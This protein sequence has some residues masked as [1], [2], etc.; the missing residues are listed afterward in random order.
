MDIISLKASLASALNDSEVDYNRIL[1]LANQISKYD[2]QNVRFSIDASHISRLGHELVSKQETAVAE[3]IKNA[4]DADANYVKAIFK[5]TYRAGGELIIVDDGLGMS[6]DELINGFMRISTRDK[7]ENPRSSKYKRQ[8][9]GR[10]GIGRFSAQRL[11]M[12]LQLTTRREEDVAGICIDIDWNK[13]EEVGDLILVSNQITSVP[14]ADVGTSLRISNLKD[15]WSNAQIQRAY[16][17]ISE[18]LQPTPLRFAPNKKDGDPGFR[19]EFYEEF[20]G[21]QEL[22]ASE[23]QN[24]LD[25]AHALI[26]GYVDENG[27]PYFSIDSKRFNY[28]GGPENFQ[29]DARVKTVFDADIADYSLLAGV[30]FQAHYFIEN[31]LPPGSRN[32]VR[33]VL[34]KNSGIKIYRNG[35]R[36]LPYGEAQDDWLGLQRSS[37]LRQ[38]LP[39][40]ANSNF[41]GFVQLTDP[42]GD[43]FEETASREG[44]IENQAFSQLQDFIY[45]SL[46]HGIIKI[47]HARGKKA[48][49]TDPSPKKTPSQRAE[50]ITSKLSTFFEKVSNRDSAVQRPAAEQAK[51]EEEASEIF[52]EIIL[53]KKDTKDLLEEIGMLRVLASLGLTI[54]EFTHETRHV[55]SALSAGIFTITQGNPSAD[56]LKTL[57][58]NIESLQAYMRYFDKAVTQN[59]QR[60]LSVHE[61]RDL[62]GDFE[63]VV[64]SALKRQFVSLKVDVSGYDLFVRPSHKSE[65]ASIFFNLFTNSL[66]AINR[67]RVLG[68]I[69]ISAGEVDDARIF[70]EFMDN[71]DGIAEENR[72]KVFDAFFTTSTPADALADDEVHITGSGLG[73][74]II[75]DIVESAGGEIFISEPPKG[76]S[77]CIRIEFPRATDEE[78]PDELR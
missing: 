49:A 65:W 37:A 54:G 14:L 19:V 32:I 64:S 17:F 2:T 10:K 62:L 7:S 55:L 11:G 27:V 74:K 59:S 50:D 8:R 69:R 77:T 72:E 18:L 21:V 63:Q 31:D 75:R 34:R 48:F 30:S 28:N 13:F 1:S 39:P 46:M 22:I 51:I 45:K 47:A 40:H 76:Y 38:L 58:A 12:R 36:V 20:D 4:Y 73:L 56:K 53:L 9:A 52:D 43:N 25:N 41:I 33:N 57:Q 3:L 61:V 35:F 66:K 24:I 78:I 23:Q 26:S 71:G 70:I 42:N 44:L 5:H 16:R 67:A 29:S 6:R 60:N 15:S 68:D